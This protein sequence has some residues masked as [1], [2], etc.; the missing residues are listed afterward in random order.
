M[1]MDFH[2][3]SWDVNG[4]FMGLSWDFIGYGMV[5]VAIAFQ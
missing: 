4:I 3:I 1:L 2:G 5:Y